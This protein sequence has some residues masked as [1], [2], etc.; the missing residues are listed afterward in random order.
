MLVKDT[1]GNAGGKKVDSEV[2]DEKKGFLSHRGGKRNFN[3]KKC[4]KQL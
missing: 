1:E 2:L 3:S 4:N